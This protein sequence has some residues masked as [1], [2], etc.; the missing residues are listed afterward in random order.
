MGRRIVNSTGSIEGSD[1]SPPSANA[2]SGVTARATAPESWLGRVG[3]FLEMIKVSHTLFAL[4]FAIGATFLAAGGW[5]TLSQF[6]W[7]VLAVLCARTAAMAF[8]RWLDRSIDAANPRTA[9]RAIPAGLLSPRFVLG[10]V[11]LS[12][13]GFVG[14]AAMLGPLPLKLSPIAL[15]VV[16]GYSAMK[17]ISFLCHLALGAALALAPIGAWIAIR[18][19]NNLPPWILGAAV[20]FWTAGF[21]IL[22]ATLD[23]DFDRERG[24]HSAPVRFGVRGSLRVAAAL[25]A[26]MIAALLLL[27]GVLDLG[28]VYFSTVLAVAGVITHEHRIV[29]PD[30][31]SRVPRAFFFWNVVI[32]LA[33]AAALMIETFRAAAEAAR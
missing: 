33:L 25:H 28:L 7:I 29:D 20:M 21:D 3:I 12:S 4:P 30:D 17:R 23:H 31:L 24:L 11:V 5:P 22:Y 14:V 10:T 9:D 2:G 8:N 19:E 13:A 26:A 1:T 32:S 15:V 16:L 27:G 6:G 18:G